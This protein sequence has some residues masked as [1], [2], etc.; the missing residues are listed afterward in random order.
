MLWILLLLCVNYSVSVVNF[1]FGQF[2]LTVTT[3]PV[4]NMLQY[5]YFATDLPAWQYT[6]SLKQVFEATKTAG[7]NNFVPDPMA[8]L[9]QPVIVMQNYPTN[10]TI[11][12]T[13]YAATTSFGTFNQ[14]VLKNVFSINGTLCPD[15]NGRFC[16]KSTHSFEYVRMPNQDMNK[17]M[18]FVWELKLNNITAT[19]MNPAIPPPIFQVVN[20]LGFY[21]IEN[22][23]QVTEFMMKNQPPKLLQKGV[24]VEVHTD[25]MTTMGIWTIYDVANM[26]HFSVVHDPIFGINKNSVGLAIEAVTIALS[27]GIVLAFLVVLVC[28]IYIYH[29]NTKE[30]YLELRLKEDLD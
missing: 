14:I 10:I 9:G 11:T 21:N 22:M 23:I 27:V 24:A 15:A 13:Y 12:V 8:Q 6:L 25:N 3:N 19:A 2:D 4:N 28:A 16:V 18:I 17:F 26:K 30:Y 29:G 5:N 20:N 1:Q 7:T